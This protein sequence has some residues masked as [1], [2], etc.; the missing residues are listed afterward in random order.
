MLTLLSTLLGLVFS[1]LAGKGLTL[2]PDQQVATTALVTSGVAGLGHWLG[3]EWH[4]RN[5]TLPPPSPNSTGTGKTAGAI[6]LMIVLAGL[7]GTGAGSLAAC[8][9]LG[10]ASPKGFDQQLA[11]AYG[12][13]TAVL[14]AATTAVTSGAISSADAIQ[15]QSMA[16]TARGF[17]DAA[18]VAESAGDPATAAGK[19]ALATNA[20]GALQTYLNSKGH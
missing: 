15:V 7:A 3:G 20:L 11:E 8:S 18:R 6:A 14:V 2:T 19:L 4:A 16:N 13:H 5:A 1:W 17:L 10:L 12:I 9:S